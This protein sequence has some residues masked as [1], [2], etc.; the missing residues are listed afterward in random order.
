MQSLRCCARGDP[1]F[2]AIDRSVKQ[3]IA[4]FL[5]MSVAL[6]C[7]VPVQAQQV[8]TKAQSAETVTVPDRKST[9][10][11]SSHLVIS[12][13]VFFFKKIKIGGFPTTGERQSRARLCVVLVVWSV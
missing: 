5:P 3:F 9:R 2:R 6:A 1:M 13:A 11:N 4:M 7:F 10:L 12:Y 8:E